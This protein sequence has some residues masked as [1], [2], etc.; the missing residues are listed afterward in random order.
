MSEEYCNHPNLAPVLLTNCLAPLPRALL[1][2]KAALAGRLRQ[3]SGQRSV[4][5]C[6]RSSLGLTEYRSLPQ[7]RSHPLWQI[8][9]PPGERAPRAA[10]NMRS[11]PLVR[12]IPACITLVRHTQIASY[13]LHHTGASVGTLVLA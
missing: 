1:A 11:S 4:P 8:S 13:R 2:R 5:I 7:V 10:Y 3:C 9:H 12:E 6:L